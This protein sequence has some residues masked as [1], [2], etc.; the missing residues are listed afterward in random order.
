MSKVISRVKP[1][2]A[3]IACAPTTPAAG[4]E[5]IVWTASVPARAAEIEPPFDCMMRSVDRPR[6]FC[7]RS[8]YRLINGAT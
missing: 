2:A 3:P 5:R 1:E 8:R 7:N 4:P 6:P